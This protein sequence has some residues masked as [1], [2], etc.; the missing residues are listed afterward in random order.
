M[1]IFQS[2]LNQSQPWALILCPFGFL[3][4]FMVERVCFN[5]HGHSHSLTGNDHEHNHEHKHEH[6]H[7]HK[8]KKKKKE[9]DPLFIN[10]NTTDEETQ[11]LS[12]PSPEL[13]QKKENPIIHEIDVP[14][15]IS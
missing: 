3:L 5:A 8:D 13:I 15:K 4:V 2:Q 6:G 1:D 9:I 11:P 12:S 14:D 7:K 10:T